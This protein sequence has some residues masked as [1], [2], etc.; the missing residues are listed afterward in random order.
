[1]IEMVRDILARAKIR[2]KDYIR[3]IGV[4]YNQLYDVDDQFI[5][6]I[7]TSED[8]ECFPK[9]S[10]IIRQLRGK[11]K[12]P[13]V[14]FEDYSKT[15][16]PYNV[17]I[18]TKVKGKIPCEIWRHM[19]ESHREKCIEDL[20]VQLQS[21]HGLDVQD[22][23]YFNKEDFY[24][25]GNFDD[26]IANYTSAKDKGRIS[27]D[28][29]DGI[30]SYI[31]DHKY[32]FDDQTLQCL[33]HCDLNLSNF[34]LQDGQV[35][36]IIDFDDSCLGTSLLDLFLFIADPAQAMEWEELNQ[37]PLQILKWVTQYYPRPFQSDHAIRILNL[38]CLFE[39]LYDYAPTDRSPISSL[40]RGNLRYDAVVGDRRIE[41][42]LVSVLN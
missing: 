24:F 32:I 38:Y 37:D 10:S 26:A 39:A 8:G 34:L 11:V 19:P 29:L 2:E 3:P 28:K 12:V 18:L 25:V 41:K 4:G 16:T 40:T 1:M 13:D 33:T 20:C 36:A 31:E 42:S 35:A 7:G 27:P 21:I 5:V 15:Y 9:S 30:W 14:V 23:S 17:M 6:R 22:N